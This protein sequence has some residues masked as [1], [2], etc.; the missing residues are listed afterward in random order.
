M[1]IEAV[2]GF[3]EKVASDEELVKQLDEIQNKAAE[4][5]EL[6]L[7]LDKKEELIK[8]VIIPFAKEQGFDF[9]IE[10]IKE[11]E[12]SIIEQLDD[13]QLEN[14]NAGRVHGG[15]GIGGFVCIAVGFGAGIMAG[16]DNQRGNIAALCVA[17]GLGFGT[18]ICFFVGTGQSLN[19]LCDYNGF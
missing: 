15:G 18:A 12:K 3:Y 16:R 9:S 5:L 19:L 11:Y 6:P 1:S 7:E 2:K 10:D 14:L 8:D 4:G 17:F 13:E